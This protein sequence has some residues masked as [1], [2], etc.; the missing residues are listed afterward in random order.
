LDIPFPLSLKL[1]LIESLSSSLI[2]IKNNFCSSSNSFNTSL[3]LLKILMKHCFNSFSYPVINK[4]CSKSKTTSILWDFIDESTKWV[5]LSIV[6]D[7]SNS[8]NTLSPLI[9]FLKS[10]IVCDKY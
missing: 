5:K 2:V 6:L 1:I 8:F 10:S 4:F 3:A 7:K 9:K